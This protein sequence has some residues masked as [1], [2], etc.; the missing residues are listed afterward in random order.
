MHSL[1]SC[2]FFC[3]RGARAGSLGKPERRRPL[4][5]TGRRERTSTS[6][7]YGKKVGVMVHTYNPSTLKERQEDCCKFESSIVYIVSSWSAQAT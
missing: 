2:P 6:R 5:W 7:I 4:S 1:P 3:F